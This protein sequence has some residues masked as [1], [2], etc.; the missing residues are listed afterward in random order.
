[1]TETGFGPGGYIWTGASVPRAPILEV[2]SS[3]A[4]SVAVAA[5]DGNP[6]YTEYAIYNDSLNF[7]IDAAGNAVTAEVWQVR[8]AWGAC[9]ASG[10]APEKRCMFRVKARNRDGIESGLGASSTA[11]TLSLGSQDIAL[12]LT[13]LK[14][15]STISPPQFMSTHD[16]G[17]RIAGKSLDDFGFVTDTISGL[18]MPGAVADEELLPGSHEWRIHDEY[19]AP[20]RIVLEGFVHGGSPT[21][22]QLRLAYI[23]SFLA[24]FGGSP[25]RST[26]PVRLERGDI[27]GRH[28]QVFYE[29]LEQAETVGRRGLS[30]SAE[31]RVSL[32]SPLPF[33]RANDVTAL[34]F[35]PTEGGFRTV[36]LG[37]APADAVY[38][39]TGAAANPSFTVGDMAFLCD[40][41]D[42]LSYADAES[43]GHEGLFSPAASENAAYCPTE[44]G[45]GIS[46]TGGNTVT[47]AAT[48]NPA[49]ASWVLALIPQ[50]QSSSM[51]EDCVVFEH[52]ADSDNFI[53]F[54]WNAAARKWVFTKRAD[55]GSSTVLSTRQSFDAG[56]RLVIGISHDSSNAGG[57]KLFVNGVLEG[58]LLDAAPLASAPSTVTLHASDGSGQVNAVFDNV[59]GWSRML[60]ADEMLRIASD[61]G[62]IIWQNTTVAYDGT[63]GAGDMLTLDSRA[64]TAQLFD[65]SAGTRTNA[66]GSLTGAV[67]PLI[68]GRKRSATDRTQTMIYTK[69]A[70]AAMLIRY[71]KQYL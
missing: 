31:L 15:S 60:S 13:V 16:S 44:T 57:M 2:L 37:N 28:W 4:I 33:S 69:N 52:H 43:E 32:K 68:P 29:A 9:P 22:L 21:D 39:L 61:T 51:T 67:P 70:P 8:A 12:P 30:S 25:W 65:I 49:D 38:V 47:Y 5:D 66:L 62:G 23:K 48:G 71:R 1:M 59:A 56:T 55:G 42:G 20:K 35:A 64:R 46:V 7:W 50:A 6:D 54:G 34:S 3:E 53:R 45:F 40:F 26:A 36:E 17:I 24:T 18:D 27:P 41:S 63:L 14:A 19:F 10:L 58:S 11:T